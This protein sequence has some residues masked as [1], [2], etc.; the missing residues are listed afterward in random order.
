MLSDSFSQSDNKLEFCALEHLQEL[1]LGKR[2][3]L[4][5]Y[6]DVTYQEGW[7]SLIE[8]LA[9][10]L[11]NYAFEITRVEDAYG[12]L[13]ISFNPL[14]KSHEIF[15]WRLL[16]EVKNQSRQLCVVCGGSTMRRPELGIK[17]KCRKCEE[18]GKG[19]TGTWLD[20]Y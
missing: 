5:H 7:K 2:F 16:H 18:T 19:G 11:K 8:T 15:V 10:E 1:A 4:S 12:Q 17:N 3:H 14:T 9:E 13:E 20:K 6:I